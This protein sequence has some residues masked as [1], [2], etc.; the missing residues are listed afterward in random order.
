V[1]SLILLELEQFGGLYG[2]DELSDREIKK[3]GIQEAENLAGYKDVNELITNKILKK[4]ETDGL[5]WT[6]PMPAESFAVNFI[7][8]KTYRG[9]NS[10][11]LNYLTEK[12]TPFWATFKQIKD[13]K[14]SVK[15]GAKSE[16][17]I[18]YKLL[19]KKGMTVI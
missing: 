4:I 7:S 6:N 14:G 16:E 13:L 2:I 3:L 18:Y 19:Y 1:G 11:I 8:K 15:K 10:L 9:V 5:I 12:A 17:V